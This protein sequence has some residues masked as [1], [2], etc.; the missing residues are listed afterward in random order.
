MDWWL[1]VIDMYD[2]IS[3]SFALYVHLFVKITYPLNVCY[4]KDVCVYVCVCAYINL[5]LWVFYRRE[6]Y[7]QH[8]FYI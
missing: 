2:M 4:K 7:V 8:P 5:G 6:L 3:L 1:H